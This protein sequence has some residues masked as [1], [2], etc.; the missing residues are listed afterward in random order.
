M[1]K[2][3]IGCCGLIKASPIES[4]VYSTHKCIIDN[5]EKTRPHG[6][7]K[8]LKEGLIFEESKWNFFAQKVHIL[9]PKSDVQS[10]ES[11]TLSNNQSSQQISEGVS[12]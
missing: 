9:I 3:Q 8:I 2:R 12:I 5:H 6:K 4:E 7:L 11:K 10:I 1:L